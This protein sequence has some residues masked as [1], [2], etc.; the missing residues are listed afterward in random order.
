VISGF[1]RTVANIF[2][3]SENGDHNS[4]RICHCDISSFFVGRIVRRIDL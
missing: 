2:C 1:N 3:K 4:L